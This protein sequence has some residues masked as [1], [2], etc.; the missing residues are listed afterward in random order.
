MHMYRDMSPRHGRLQGFGST[1]WLL[2]NG[3]KDGKKLRSFDAARLLPKGHAGRLLHGQIVARIQER[4][5]AFGAV[6]DAHLHADG[7]GH[8]DVEARHLGGDGNLEGGGPLFRIGIHG[9]AEAAEEGGGDRV[10]L[11]LGGFEALQEFG[12]QGLGFEAAGEGR[13]GQRAAPVGVACARQAWWRTLCLG[14]EDSG[15]G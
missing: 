9:L 11:L 2:A 1:L 14:S 13:R 10:H 15:T 6:P 12:R 4:V 5:C 7:H 3:G 8:E